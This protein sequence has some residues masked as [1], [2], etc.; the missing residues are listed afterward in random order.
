MLNLL[1]IVK[2]EICFQFVTSLWVE[3]PHGES[4]ACHVGSHWSSVSGYIKYLLS[5]MTSQN[6]VIEESSNFMSWSSLRYVTT[7]WS[8][9]LAIGIV[10]VETFLVCQVIK[11]GHMIKGSG[12]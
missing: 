6:H 11:Q 10:E 12:D 4:P 1:S 5:Q 2:V 9:L 8:S 7:T 3:A